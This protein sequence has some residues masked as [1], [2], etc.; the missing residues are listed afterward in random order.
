F[1]PEKVHI[2]FDERSWELNRAKGILLELEPD[3]SGDKKVRQWEFWSADPELPLNFIIDE[4]GNVSGT[5]TD[6]GAESFDN[7]YVDDKGR[8]IVPIISFADE[9]ESVGY[10]NPPSQALIDAQ[11][12]IDA[13]ETNL[14]HIAKQQGYGQWVSEVNPQE[15]D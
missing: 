3:C 6:D 9:D 1:T 15:R 4:E 5:M 10:W 8:P 7:P 14:Q 11:M 12:A 2:W 13:N